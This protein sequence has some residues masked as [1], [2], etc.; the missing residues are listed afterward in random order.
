MFLARVRRAG[1]RVFQE[2]R[3]ISALSET[4]KRRTGLVVHRNFRVV[5]FLLQ[6]TARDELLHHVKKDMR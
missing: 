2:R 4:Q 6:Q 5:L 1:V 3:A